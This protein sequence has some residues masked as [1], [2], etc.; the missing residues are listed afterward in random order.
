MLSQAPLTF[1]T[2][3]DVSTIFSL[4]VRS[5]LDT[6]RQRLT[7][8]ANDTRAKFGNS[9]NQEAAKI[10]EEIETAEKAI[11]EIVGFFGNEN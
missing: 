11:K 5:A 6:T 7:I 8:A 2:V 9:G 10:V 3:N 4:P 1:A